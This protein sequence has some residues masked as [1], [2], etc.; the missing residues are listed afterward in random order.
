MNIFIKSDKITSPGGEIKAPCESR[1]EIYGD[2][3]YG[4][5]IKVHPAQHRD[6]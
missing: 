2:K 1:G 3:I 5:E 4:E 6:L